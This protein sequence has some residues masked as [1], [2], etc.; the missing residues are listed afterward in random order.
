MSSLI[1]AYAT[2]YQSK[3]TEA[4]PSLIVPAEKNRVATQLPK[5]NQKS[6]KPHKTPVLLSHILTLPL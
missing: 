3:V 2:L 5:R 6:P 1:K 4:F